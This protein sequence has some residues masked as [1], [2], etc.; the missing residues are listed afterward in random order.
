MIKDLRLSKYLLFKNSRCTSHEVKRG[1]SASD[2]QSRQWLVHELLAVGIVVFQR[3]S[4][5]RF[6]RQLVV[7]TFGISPS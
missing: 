6:V 3:S 2:L 1:E 5:C 7:V 4:G